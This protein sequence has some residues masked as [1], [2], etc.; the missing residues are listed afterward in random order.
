M[1][2]KLTTQDNI[3]ELADA[4]LHVPMQ[5]FDMKG[6][7]LPNATCGTAGCIAGHAMAIWPETYK[8]HKVCS[9]D[10]NEDLCQRIGITQAQ[11]DDLF[12]PGDDCL[13]YT[14]T[15][16][17]ISHSDITRAGAAATLLR[18]AETGEVEWRKSEQIA[19][20]DTK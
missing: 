4:I 14:D 18:L 1:L 9:F 2:K 20:D 15:G 3:F 16:E 7:A 11:A 8:D 6:T 19:H 17:M 5:M 13:E 12:Y 10:C